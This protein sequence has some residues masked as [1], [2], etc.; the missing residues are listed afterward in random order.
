MSGG[1]RIYTLWASM[2]GE[3]PAPWMMAAEDES[4]WEGDP[5]R[6][7]AAFAD[8]RRRAKDSDWDVRELTLHV[9]YAAID[10]AFQPADIIV[11][12]EPTA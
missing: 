10:A 6:C 7:E 12:V 3:E 9:F 1:Y 2:K 8:A 5:D 11:S 4:S